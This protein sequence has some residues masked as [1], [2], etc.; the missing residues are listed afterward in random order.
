MRKLLLPIVLVLCTL[1]VSIGSLRFNKQFELMGG[2]A[3]EYLQLAI[4][5]HYTG[6]LALPDS[7]RPFVFR[8]PGYVKFLQVVLGASGAMKPQD[9]RFSSQQ[10]YDE[11]MRGML[12]AIYLAQACLAAGAALILFFLLR[13]LLQ[14]SAAFVLALAFG[15]HPYLVV[16]VGMVHYEMLHLFLLLLSTWLLQTGIRDHAKPRGSVLLTLSGL[17]W[18]VTTLTRPSTLVLPALLGVAL[19]IRFRREWRQALVCWTLFTMSFLAAIAPW[20]LRNYRAAG[21]LIPVN[22][23]ANAAMWACAHKPLPLDANHYRWAEAWMPDGHMTYVRITERQD[24]STAAYADHVLELEEAFRDQFHK[25]LSQQPGVYLANAWRNFALMTFGMNSVFL[26]VFQHLQHTD[27]GVQAPW[28]G[29][30]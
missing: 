26:K 27:G 8:P 3:E 30:V 18:G 1:G 17:A 22:A 19:A 24:F 29:R 23:Q 2:M 10:E 21:R 9:H 7:T 28:L 5:M 13:E 15:I 6:D 11:A 14:A 25:D 16:H 20:T 12:N 4:H